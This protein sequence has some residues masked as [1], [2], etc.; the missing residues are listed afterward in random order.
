MVFVFLFERTAKLFSRIPYGQPVRALTGSI[1]VAALFLL[2]GRETLGTSR[3]LYGNLIGGEL[4]ALLS[5]EPV[6]GNTLL[7]LVLVIAVK[8]TATSF[9]VG[10]GM[11]GGFTGP[12]VILG[13][14][15][16][17]LMSIPAGIAPGEPSYY[18]FLACSLPAILGAVMNIPIAAAILAIELFGA[19]YTLP[20]VVGG[21]V[22]FLLVR[23]RSVYSRPRFPADPD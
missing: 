17:A 11:S 8:I 12:L 18:I 6:M 20:A 14:A 23:T 10:S 16:G 9:T 3:E 19:D 22:S 21:I 13:I 15:S 4:D 5:F 7:V 1:A 2:M